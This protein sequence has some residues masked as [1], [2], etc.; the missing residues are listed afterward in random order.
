MA[1]FV[2]LFGVLFVILGVLGVLVPEQAISLVGGWHSGLHFAFG[3]GVRILL[4]VF[5]LVAASRCRQPIVVRVIGI[6]ALVAA[7][8]MLVSG[9]TRFEHFIASCL[10]RPPG[11]MRAWSTA[12]IAVGVLLV[13]AGRRSR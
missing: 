9:P 4:G 1:F 2:S 6:I 10:E 11:V 13:W 7:V 12:G 5:L 8:G 3:A